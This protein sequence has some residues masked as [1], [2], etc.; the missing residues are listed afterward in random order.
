MKTLLLFLLL[1]QISLAQQY[2]IRTD[3]D[4][5]RFVGRSLAISDSTIIMNGFVQLTPNTIFGK[6]CFAT[7][8][9]DGELKKSVLFDSIGNIFSSSF[10]RTLHLLNDSSFVS[11]INVSDS[12]WY[13][14]IQTF[15][16]NLNTLK[17]IEY[18]N[19]EVDPN[20]NDFFM[21]IYRKG[22]TDYV[23]SSRFDYSSNEHDFKVY[24]FDTSGVLMDQRQYG[25]TGVWNRANSMVPT[26]HNTFIIGSSKQ[27]PQIASGNDWSQTWLIEIDTNL[28]ILKEWTDPNDSTYEGGT[29][30][31]LEDGGLIFSTVKKLKTM[32][33]EK[34]V[35]N[36]LLQE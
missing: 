9:L 14:R 10:S 2:S 18:R 28:N 5:Y 4:R 24:K 12:V 22:S 26:N 33:L 1:S 17:T 3:L 6:S 7:F 35:G 11:I 8:D 23:Q 36:C 13:S 27:K 34:L 31:P 19:P 16:L 21:K 20:D 30:L 29:I 15:D 25:Q 32:V